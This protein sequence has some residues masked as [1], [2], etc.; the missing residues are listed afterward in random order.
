[1]QHLSFCVW[2]ISI[3]LIKETHLSILDI[4]VSLIKYQLTIYARFYF[5]ALNSITLIYVGIFMPVA[6]YLSY[7]IFAVQFETRENDI[8]SFVPSR[9][10][11]GCLET[12]VVPHGASL[13]ALTK[14]I[15]LRC[16]DQGS[17]L[18][19]G[20]SPS[21]GMVTTPVFLPGEFQRQKT[22]RSQSVGHD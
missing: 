18:L 9:D 3:F 10:Y 20:R 6:Y 14:R 4:L 1:M 7:N 17:I 19:S 11:F 15:W 21:K 8:S 5:W 16:G 22:L 13:V 12:F 2:L